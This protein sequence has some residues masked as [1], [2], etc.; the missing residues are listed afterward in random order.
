MRIWLDHFWGHFDSYTWLQVSPFRCLVEGFVFFSFFVFLFCILLYFH[1]S[2]CL[3]MSTGV[4]LKAG[5]GPITS[6]ANL[7]R[8]N[9]LIKNMINQCNVLKQKKYFSF[10]FHNN[11]CLFCFSWKTRDWVNHLRQPY[12]PILQ[13]DILGKDFIWQL[14]FRINFL[15]TILCKSFWV[16]FGTF[17]Y[18]FAYFAQTD[19]M[20]S[21]YS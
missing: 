7:P 9:H 13:F 8:F 1:L 21:I 12:P 2:A 5:K 14:Q 17:Q 11:F 3:P 15:K 10:T 4:W 6:W 18:H 20:F 19:Q 16:L